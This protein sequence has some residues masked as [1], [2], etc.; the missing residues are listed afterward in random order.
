MGNQNKT[1]N[2]STTTAMFSLTKL[3]SAEAFRNP[4]DDG[5]DYLRGTVRCTDGPDGARKGKVFFHQLDTGDEDEATSIS[6]RAGGFGADRVAVEIY[7]EQPTQDNIS[8][9]K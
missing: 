7:D 9:R 5:Q 1:N 2:Q 8:A 3:A 4:F 6:V